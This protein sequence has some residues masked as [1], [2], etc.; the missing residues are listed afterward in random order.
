MPTGFKGGGTTPPVATPKPQGPLEQPH[1]ALQAAGFNGGIQQFN[2]K[3]QA[4]ADAHHHAYG[5]LPSPGLTLDVARSDVQPKDYPTLFSVPRSPIVA[6]AQGAL[7]AQGI[8]VNNPPKQ[9]SVG[10]QFAQDLKNVKSSEALNAFFDPS[11]KDLLDA[12]MS[13]PKSKRAF[14]SAYRQALERIHATKEGANGE[15]PALQENVLPV[16]HNFLSRAVGEGGKFASQIGTGLLFGPPTLAIAEGKAVTKAFETGSLKPV[17][18]ENVKLAKGVAKGVAQD[19][20]H[21]AEN[22]G[23]LFLDVLGLF[24][25]G[26]GAAGRIGRAATALGEGEGL[27]GAAK[28]AARRPVGGTAELTKNGFAEDQLLTENPA[29]RW[30]QKKLVNIRNKRM[31]ER[32]DEPGG[33]LSIVNPTKLQ[34]ALDQ[35]LDPLRANFSS[36]N[37]LGREARARRR[38][39]TTIDM[40]IKRDLDE[41]AGWTQTAGTI[42]HAIN[43]VLPEKHRGLTVGEQKAIQVLATDAED[44]IQAWRDFHENMIASGIGDPK[45]HRAQLAALRLAEQAIANPSKRFQKA[46]D[47]TREV[48]AKQQKIKVD[49]LG[50]LP[51]TANKR[52]LAPGQVIRGEEIRPGDKVNPESFYLPFASKGKPRRGAGSTRTEAFSPQA[53]FG[54]VPMPT[55]PPELRHEFTGKSIIAGDFRIDSTALAGDAYARTV[56]AATKLNEWKKLWASASDKPKDLRFDRPIRDIQGIPDQLRELVN[57]ATD[58]EL[59]SEE[60][61]GLHP[62]DIKDLERFLF[63][64]RK[65][66]DKWVLDE[67]IEHVKWVDSRLLDSYHQPLPAAFRNTASVL[68]EP[69]RDFALFLRPAYIL[70]LLGNSGMLAFDQGLSAI[71]NVLRAV[72]ADDIYGNKV[73]HT[74]DALGGQIGRSAS[75]APLTTGEGISRVL[76]T[77]GRTLS[78]AWNVVTDQM[79]RRASIIGQLRRQAKELKLDPN[80]LETLLFDPKYAKQRNEAVRRGNKAMVEFDNLAWIER[81]ALRHLIFV[82]PWTSR[83]AVWSVRSII[84]HPVEAA[85]L[86]QI[87]REAEDEFPDVL[88]KVPEWFKQIGYVPI[89]FNNDGSPK[90]VNPSSI[91]TFSTFSQLLYPL[92]AGFTSSKYSSLSDLFGPGATFAIHGATG[93]DQF[94][95]TYPGSQ[96]LGAAKEVWGQLPQLR[97]VLRKSGQQAKP[98][99]LSSRN[100][101][102]TRMNESLKETV[103]TPGWLNGWGALIAGGLSP[104]GVNPEAA[105]ARWYRDLPLEQKHEVEMDLIH[106]A[107]RLQAGLLNQK[108][109]SNISDAVDLTGARQLAY[110]QLKKKLGRTP[111][112]KEQIQSDISV[113]AKNARM[114]PGERSVLTAKLNDISDPNALDRFR[115]GL[116]DKYGYAKDLQNWDE[117]VRFVYS[118]RPEVLKDKLKSLHRQGLADSPAVV[119]KQDDLYAWGRKVLAY[120]SEAKQRATEIDKTVF[121]TS[122][123]KEAAQAEL[124]SWMDDHDKPVKI[125]GRT[126]PSPVRMVWANSTPAEQQSHLRSVAKQ[127]WG[128]LSNFDKQLLGIKTDPIASK[129]WAQVDKWMSEAEAQLGPGKRLPNGTRDYYAKIVADRVPNFKKD[130]LFSQNILADRMKV[131]KVVTNSPNK[132]LWNE[133]LSTASSRYR[134][135]LDAKWSKSSA[136]DQWR[137][138]D[139]PKIETWLKSHPDFKREVDAYGPSFLAS[140]VKR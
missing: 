3:V 109:P 73:A 93:K 11:N 1:P 52:V 7:K 89:G 123:D 14:I 40:T 138:N 95:N 118:F 96:W 104:R 129:G 71:P 2:Q 74:I 18:H 8:A 119:G 4:I 49:E 75:Y 133:L 88:K 30:A 110:D 113:L 67:P 127:S 107:L 111:T 105:Q 70:N 36:E 41:V 29:L 38:I 13:D 134:Q 5:S 6:Q 55:T 48:I 46:L 60:A 121:A 128:S 130:Y 28:V 114:S 82:Y 69:F 91:N 120:Y 140:L 37:K 106:R 23:N 34:D 92:E 59:T 42:K 66:G 65:V 12:A 17:V 51:D 87:G 136:A 83:A 80:D 81:E 64:G 78:H 77:P 112:V 100:A 47:L 101:L 32:T 43:R 135:L 124:R 108:L 86:N 102:V 26:A 90:V 98:L 24:S 20:A 125:N 25:A 122:A 10:M 62:Q 9:L 72:K 53:G 139:V 117:K 68:N 35:A 16:S 84:E 21:P 137:Q 15:L 63:P 44:P 27:L 31:A 58:A 61:D 22:P 79:L 57:K 45:A 50:L 56:K 39:E 116:L 54:G 19:V 103:F 99:D 94:G 131:M 33:L 132:P 76:T 115:A 97:P 85:L 126:Y